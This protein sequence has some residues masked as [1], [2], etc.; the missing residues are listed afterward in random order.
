MVPNLA[1]A[2]EDAVPSASSKSERAYEWVRERINR[3]EYGP[4]YRL[5]LGTIADQL[6]M[7]V[8]PVREAIRRLEAEGL[9]TFERNVGAKVTLVNAADYVNTMESLGIIEGAATALSAPLL[10]EATLARAAA[11]N[12]RMEALLDH[13]DPHTFTILNQQFHATLFEVCPNAHLVELVQRDWVRLAGLRDSTFAF[14]P[15]RARHSVAEHGEIL[16]LIR[17]GADPREIEEAA[18]AHRWHTLQAY[19]EARGLTPQN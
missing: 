8:V 9:V 12:E 14:V 5:V 4:G 10:D 17:T 16:R 19:R 7:S 3:Q 6:E 18:R 15:G 2:G 1:I 11:I 13:F